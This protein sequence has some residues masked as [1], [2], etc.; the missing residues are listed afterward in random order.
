MGD[1]RKS[2]RIFLLK[3]SLNCLKNNL[4]KISELYNDSLYFMPA[5]N[6]CAPYSPDLAPCDY[7]LFSSMGH[8]LDEQHFD[9]CE[10]VENWV[11]DWFALK[12]EQFY[13]RGIHKLPERW[14][15]CVENNGQYFE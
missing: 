4:C 15:K 10:E 14:S 6:H 5:S 3:N 2:G 13:W 9:S 8:A 1:G 12:D 11:S 7:H